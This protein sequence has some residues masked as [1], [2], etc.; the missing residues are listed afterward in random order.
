MPRIGKL[1]VLQTKS[2]KN[3]LSQ[4]LAFSLTQGPFF[5]IWGR[6]WYRFLGIPGTSTCYLTCVVASLLDVQNWKTKHFVKEV[7]QKSTFAEVGI[8]IVS[9]SI[10]HDLGSPLEPISWYSW[11]LNMLFGILGGFTLA[12]WG[13]LGRSWDTGERKEGHFDAQACMFIDSE[14][15]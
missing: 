15:I 7:L 11:Y 1:S 12:S 9:G 3:Q 14:Q 10:F 8:L 13:T 4:K 6:L 5:M 2:C